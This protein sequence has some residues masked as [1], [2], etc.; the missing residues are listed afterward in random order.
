MT[1]GDRFGGGF[2]FAGQDQIKYRGWLVSEDFK[3][4]AEHEAFG[5]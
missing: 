3:G 2:Q 1:V 5:L 4:L